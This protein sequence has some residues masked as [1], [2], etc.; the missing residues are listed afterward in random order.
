M[1]H[2]D[3]PAAT[4]ATDAVDLLAQAFPEGN[5]F[6]TYLGVR[7]THMQGGRAEL[8]LDINADHLNSWQV[9]H[10][11]VTMTLLDVAMAMAGRSLD[12]DARSGVT[13]EMKTSFFQPAGAPGAH[14]VAKGLAL[15]RSTTL[16]YCEGELWNG[17]RLVAKA[18][19][20]FKYLKA[21]R[22]GRAHGA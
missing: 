7:L 11:G 20:T 16:C 15:H 10:G 9:V 3:L 12:P 17:G 14:L 4:A 6:L 5:P 8:R 13:V 1:A 19:G 18:M 22:D 21:P 2:E